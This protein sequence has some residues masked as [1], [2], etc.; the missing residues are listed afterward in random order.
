MAVTKKYTEV[1]NDRWSFAVVWKDENGNPRDLTGWTA[2]CTV[3][4]SYDT[5]GA[6]A[7]TING[8]ISAP[9]TGRADFAGFLTIPDG[10]YV[11]DVEFKLG[12]TDRRTL[13]RGTLE[14]LPE[15]T[16]A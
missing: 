9:L 12:S 4:T 5:T 16:S 14:V 2:V 13:V 11:Y 10:K 3:R 15:V 8:V 7:L 6:A 1:E